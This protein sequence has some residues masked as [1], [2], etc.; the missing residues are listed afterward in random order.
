LIVDAGDGLF[1]TV[2]PL[3]IN[4]LYDERYADAGN[5]LSILSLSF[6][7]IKDW[8][9]QK[10]L[11]DSYDVCIIGAGPAGITLALRFAGNGRRVL[12]LEGGGH[13]YS[14]HSQSLY[15]CPSTSLDVYAEETR[16][17]YLGGTSNH[18]AL[19]GVSWNT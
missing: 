7:M 12:L 9:T 11:R 5:M 18:W 17:R 8:Q 15:Q 3:L 16:L 19:A 10:E 14:Q 6:F 2:S 4:L 13:E 1:W